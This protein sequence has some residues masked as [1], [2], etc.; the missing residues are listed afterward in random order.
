MDDL[1]GLQ[2]ETA[3]KLQSASDQ[4]AA[5]SSQKLE[6]QNKLTELA[7]ANAVLAHQLSSVQQEKSRLLEGAKDCEVQLVQRSLDMDALRAQRDEYHDQAVVNE[8]LLHAARS[9]EQESARKCGQLHL[10]LDM[11]L[12][13]A[14]DLEARLEQAL[15][16]WKADK[17]LCTKETQRCAKLTATCSALIERNEDLEAELRRY[18]HRLKQ[19]GDLPMPVTY[20]N[21]IDGVGE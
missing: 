1:Q 4:V 13:H 11:Q 5:L 21:L 14:R 18:D 20:R 17:D 10:Q 16:R 9:S 6:Y 7:N 15:T 12:R 2:S 3:A 19:Y 8:Q